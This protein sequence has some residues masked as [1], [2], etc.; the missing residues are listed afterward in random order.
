[1]MKFATDCHKPVARVLSDDPDS[2]RP[3]SLKSDVEAC[4]GQGS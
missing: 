3:K 4:E 1:M 2:R